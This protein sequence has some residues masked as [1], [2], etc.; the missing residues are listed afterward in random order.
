MSATAPMTAL[1]SLPLHLLV[2]GGALATL[3]LAFL[4]L[5][6]LPGLLHWFR[7]RRIQ[8]EIGRLEPRTPPGEFRRV[9]ARDRRLALLWK[10]FE[11]SLHVQ[12]EERDGQRATVAVRS[13]LP[14]ETFF[15][16]QTVVDARLRTEFFKHLP[17]I[18]TGIGII[19]TFT[20][21]IEGL[22]QFQVSENAAAVRTSLESLMHSVGQAFLISATAIAAAIAVTFL[23]K[24]LL[25]A[26]YGRTED[27]AH[28]ID[29]RFDA[30]AGEEYLS[31]LVQAS[32]GAARHSQALKDA[33]VAEIAGVMREQTDRQISGLATALSA[34]IERSLAAP[35]QQI[36]AAVQ[37]STNDQ[38]TQ[39]SQLLQDV[40]GRFSD[41]L[42]D[43]LG[44]QV[45]NI[46]ALNQQT[47]QTMQDAVQA[48]RALVEQISATSRQS[49][50]AMTANLV[51]ATRS[52]LSALADSQ[53]LS[54]EGQQQRERA[55][56]Q[57]STAA[58][59]GL[60]ELLAQALTE[61]RGSS[62][63][64]AC[65]VAAMAQTTTSALDTMSSGA[66]QLS[67]ASHS[68]ASAG[69]R[70]SGVMEQAARVSSQLADASNLLVASAT[71]MRS[72]LDDYRAHREAVGHLVT[73]LRATVEH[74][75]TE[76]TLTA[77]VLDRIQL[78]TERLGQAHEQADLYLNSVSKVL[79]E[80]HQAFAIAVKKTL[81]LANTEFHAKLSTAVGLL[82]STV[83]ELEATLGNVAP[84]RH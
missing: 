6:L 13:T 39:T 48:V 64:M 74:A 26:L 36:A 84:Q 54:V 25:S 73:E 65:S 20:G 2:A 60:S 75:R 7:L 81:G 14:A 66:S 10:E 27:L 17:G 43:V 44:G 46:H 22:R 78:S 56:A 83:V 29:A 23:E 62:A 49:N 5:F 11:D 82:S 16:G 28:A 33:L 50:D 57:R 31:R 35:L 52:M 38:S 80:A 63:Q 77:D 72:G 9:F 55:M 69:D 61:M 76:A 24:L 32:E 42:H 79:G 67:A 34:S 70:V 51:D 71:D 4:A 40:M 30:G 68:F 41:R 37:A 15:N 21:L 53:R 45:S 59:D 18:Y 1:Y 58:V 19:G 12:R 3:L 8:R 47:G